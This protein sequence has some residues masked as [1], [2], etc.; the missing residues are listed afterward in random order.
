MQRY[1]EACLQINLERN[2]EQWLKKYD[3][4][5]FPVGFQFE[6]KLREKIGSI[7]GIEVNSNKFTFT[8][9]D[10]KDVEFDVF[11]DNIEADVLSYL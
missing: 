1:S 7:N 9:Y 11:C 10:G 8:A 4:D 5:L 3:V 2:V 6:N